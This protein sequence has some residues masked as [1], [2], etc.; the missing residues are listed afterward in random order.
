V[1][2]YN[3][4]IKQITDKLTGEKEEDLKYLSSQADKYRDHE[5]GLEILRAIGRIITNLLPDEE[6]SKLA[7]V[8]KNEAL[9]IDVVLNEAR[10]K[11]EEH[12][13]EEA[14]KMILRILPDEDLYQPDKVSEYYDFRNFWERAFFVAKYEPSKEIRQVPISYNEVFMVYAYILVEKEEYE[15]AIRIIDLGVKRNPLHIDLLFEKASIYRSLKKYDQSFQI[16]LDFVDK[17]YRRVNIARCYRDFGYYFIENKK[18]EAAIS[19]YLLS[20]SWFKSDMAKNELFYITQQTQ[21]VIDQEY[22]ADHFEEVLEKHKIPLNPNPLWIQIA[23]YLGEKACADHQFEE[24]KFCYHVAYELTGDDSYHEKILKIND[25][26][27]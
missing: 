10:K 27:A 1:A 21:K 8:L 20:D 6:M 7:N 2:E 12:N 14:E 5:Y 9:H 3:E 17:A 19:C 18:W 25:E 16:S 13:L 11:L 15:N 22:F 23:D 4:I 24:A 26:F